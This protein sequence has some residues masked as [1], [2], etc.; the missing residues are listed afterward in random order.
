M[1]PPVSDRYRLEMRLGRDNDLEEWLATD[2]SLER[3]VL[4][5]S[6][7]PE[8]SHVRR[9]G[10]VASVSGAAK[11]SHPHL[12]R[13]FAVEDV[14]GGAYAVCEWTGG[15]SAA[16]RLAA[17]R[18]VGLEE[19]LPNASGLA[20][21]LATLHE[22]GA[23]HGQLDLSAISWSVAHPA[24]LGGFG[25]EPR[26]DQDGDVR[27]LAAALETALTGSP[28]GGPP[29]SESIDGVPRTIDRVLR[30][31]QSGRL[32]AAD[33]EK[34]LLASPTLRAAQPEPLSTSR[35]LLYVAAGLVVLAV[36]LVALGRLFIGGGP[37]IPISPTTTLSDDP[38]TT[39]SAP[40]GT[41]LPPGPVRVVDFGSFD[42]F[43]E[44]GENDE[45]IGIVLDGSASTTWRSER[46]QDPL[47]LVKP[48]VGLRFQV[49]GAPSAVQF[50]GLTTGTEFGI[51]WAQDPPDGIE[52]WERALSATADSSTTLL[53][54]P[55]REGGHWLLWMTD[56][57]QQPDG[58]FYAELG[59]VRFTP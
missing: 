30:S 25:R 7:G 57:P 3:P 4:I 10:F 8:S 48:G 1:P 42:P 32:D 20:G 50:V 28:P 15:A 53:P 21:A 41:T 44:G 16:D 40:A 54:L 46:Y 49:S 33:L 56:F 31:A 58:T 43:G 5:R 59:E 19:F 12:A 51:Y 38:V 26:T 9:E 14:A 6:L 39:T 52:G 55:P 27:A 13:V 29:P 34:A 37:I 45:A 47:S 2:T 24:K 11:T 22:S 23:V 17:D 36:G 35:R 18:T